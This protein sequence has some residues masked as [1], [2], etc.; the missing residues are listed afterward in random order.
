MRPMGPYMVQVLPSEPEHDEEVEDLI[1]RLN[2]DLLEGKIWF[3]PCATRVEDDLE[4]EVTKKRFPGTQEDI[5]STNIKTEKFGTVYTYEYIAEAAHHD[6]RFR[7]AKELID[8]NWP[9]KQQEE[10]EVLEEEVPTLGGFL[11][12]ILRL[13]GF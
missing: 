5:F 13:F 11:S 10:P 12:K 1:A 3:D 7:I 2:N 4:I 6:K 8:E 9:R